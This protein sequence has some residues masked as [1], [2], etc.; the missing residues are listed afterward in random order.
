MR[1]LERVADVEEP[2]IFLCPYCQDTGIV[3][4]IV[5]QYDVGGTR[6][7]GK[8]RHF[9]ATASEE[10]PIAVRCRCNRAPWRDDA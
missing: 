9:V 5:G 3:V 4:R 8:I 1:A 7:G 6:N 2:A 10:H